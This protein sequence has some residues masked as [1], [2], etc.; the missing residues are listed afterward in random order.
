MLKI[1]D[2]KSKF[3]K[4]GFIVRAASYNKLLAYTDGLARTVDNRDR[5]IDSVTEDYDQV[6]TKLKAA[7]RKIEAMIKKYKGA[8]LRD[9]DTGK[10][11]G[12]AK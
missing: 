5:Q 1:N 9:P 6:N 7:E 12:L 11:T 8:M 10:L 2:L 3:Q 4:K